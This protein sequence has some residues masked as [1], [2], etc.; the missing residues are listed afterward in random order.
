MQVTPEIYPPDGGCLL[1]HFPKWVRATMKIQVLDPAIEAC[2]SEMHGKLKDGE[3][4]AT[5]RRPARLPG[6]SERRFRSRWK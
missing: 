3:K 1:A 4:I 6:A 5:Q 2:F